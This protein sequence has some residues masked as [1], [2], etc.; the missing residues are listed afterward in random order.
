M[1]KKTLKNF[2]SDKKIIILGFAKEG[3]DTYF[4]LRKIDRKK[5]LAIA[6]QKSFE[7][8]PSSL[9]NILQKDKNTKLFLG[10]SYLKALKD[11]D[12]VI[13][14][15]GIA[16]RICKK[17]L[18]KKTIVTSQTALFFDFCPGLIIG[19]T[20]TKGKGTTAS[21]IYHI[22]KK[23]GKKAVL[24]GN[25]GKPV[26]QLLLKSSPQHIYVYE[27]SSHQLQGLSK[28]P[29]IAVFLNLFADHLDYYRNFQEYKKA[30]MVIT[31]YQTPKDFLV[32]NAQ[33]KYVSQIAQQ[34]K[35]QKI[36]FSL[37]EKNTFL[38]EFQPFQTCLK[39]DFNFLNIMAAIKTVKIFH[40]K[41]EIITK[42]LKTFK[43][44]AHRLQW[45]G[46][47]NNI[48]FYN[49]S[50]ATVPQSTI[51]DLKTFFPQPITLIVGGSD[52]G[53][54][55][56]AL[57]REIIHSSV[58][59]LVVLGDGTGKKIAGLVKRQNKSAKQKINFFFAPHMKEAIRI[60]YEHTP[61]NG[62][63]LLSPASASFNLFQSY[64]DRGEQFERFVKKMSRTYD[65][66][67]Y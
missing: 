1:L 48:D 7:Q 41:K 39:G 45:V 25:I 8:F 44:L 66:S 15:P 61:Q 37:Q 34:S 3:Q 21:L 19:V 29:H 20:G 59:N 50:M 60:C 65:G 43:G 28:S 31:L 10:D 13:K 47:Y 33:D 12:F 58:R 32:Y 63:C 56:R 35:A 67:D 38:Q 53:S 36:P 9:R 51:E 26:F 4:A 57:A 55:Y 49:N 40:I 52:K 2:F 18:S 64:E 62:V 54:D 11:Y 30:K 46:K 17:F 27:L 22:L 14:T 16:P 24:V 6:D 23:A 42:A 5:P